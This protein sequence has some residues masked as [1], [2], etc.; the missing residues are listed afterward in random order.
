[1]ARVRL[2]PDAPHLSVSLYCEHLTDREAF[3]AL[4]EVV[5]RRGGASN[6]YVK[7]IPAGL[8]YRSL[9]DLPVDVRVEL[10]VDAVEFDRL[11]AGDDPD[12]TV[13][14]AEFMTRE[15]GLLV[16]SQLSRTGGDRHP[17]DA[18]VYADAL[19][20]P[21][22]AWEE[23]DEERAGVLAAWARG[24][25]RA[26]CEHVDPLYAEL[27]IETTLATPS[28][29]GDADIGN[30]YVAD[31]LLVADPH[32]EHD[33]RMTFETGDVARWRTGLYCSTWASF[34]EAGRSA[35]DLSRD[36]GKTTG[37]LLARAWEIM[38]YDPDA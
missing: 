23:G 13:V 31:R 21:P 14:K 6:G 3:A 20:I 25:F 10:A 29:L 30:V 15:A 38:T 33:L 8:E 26:A 36:I 22:W 37:W 12:R 27:T 2:Y 17:V 4:A 7:V 5:R 35:G 9:T 28:A 16:V 24:L 19:G 18:S 11:V 34:N 1:M 32:L